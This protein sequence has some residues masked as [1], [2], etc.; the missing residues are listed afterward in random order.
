MSGVVQGVFYRASTQKK[1]RELGVV[2]WVRNLP[3]QQVEIV[4]EGPHDA[5][6]RL[7]AWCHGG[8]ERAVVEAVSATWSDAAGDFTDFDIR[9]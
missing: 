5:L 6:Q 8:P 3:T 2:G 4:A 9:R 7:V 1:A